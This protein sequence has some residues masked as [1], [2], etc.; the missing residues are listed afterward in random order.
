MAA[1][2]LEVIDLHQQPALATRDHVV[3]APTLVRRLP[4]PVRRVVGEIGDSAWV[5]LGLDSAV[6]SDQPAD[7]DE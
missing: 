3:A 4:G 7:L 1:F 6:S 5:S 2:N